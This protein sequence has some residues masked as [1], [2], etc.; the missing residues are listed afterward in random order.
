ME[1]IV[2][3]PLFQKRI[4]PLEDLKTFHYFNYG[5]TSLRLNL[6]KLKISYIVSADTCSFHAWFVLD[7]EF[8]SLSIAVIDGPQ[9][10]FFSM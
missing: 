10:S 9:S 8:I 7:F 3:A 6:Y 2:E 1:F 5:L 4:V